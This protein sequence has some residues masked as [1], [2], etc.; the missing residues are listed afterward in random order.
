MKSLANIFLECDS[1]YH[2][3]L[4]Y[5]SLSA[6]DCEVFGEALKSNRSLFGLHLAGNGAYLDDIGMV[7]SQLAHGAPRELEES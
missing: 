2:L 3:D 7:R 1:L 6:S 5:N 4:S